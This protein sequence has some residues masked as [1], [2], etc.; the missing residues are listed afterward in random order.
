MAKWV[1]VNK[2]LDRAEGFK[3]FDLF[4]QFRAV[5]C[6]LI[7]QIED[8]PLKKV[9]NIPEGVQE[10]RVLVETSRPLESKDFIVR[11]SNTGNSVVEGETNLSWSRKLKT[12]FHYCGIRTN[13]G[14]VELRPFMWSTCADQMTVEIANWQSKDLDKTVLDFQLGAELTAQDGR[15][16][17]I[18][19]KEL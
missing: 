9:F 5:A 17:T 8:L 15:R 10:F 18:I 16:V 2:V 6:S 1:T 4:A 19:G 11:I 12:Y 7:D 3:S 14:W 13:T